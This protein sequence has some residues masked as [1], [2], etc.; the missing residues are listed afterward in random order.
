MRDIIIIKKEDY[1]YYITFKT[2]YITFK[3]IIK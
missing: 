2:Y 1:N 3:I